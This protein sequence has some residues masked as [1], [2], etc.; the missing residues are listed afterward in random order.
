MGKNQKIH[1]SH[2]CST[3]NSSPIKVFFSFSSWQNHRSGGQKWSSTLNAPDVIVLLCSHNGVKPIVSMLPPSSGKKNTF[4]GRLK[5]ITSLGRVSKGH[6]QQS[7]KPSCNSY[8]MEPQGSAGGPPM[9]SFVYCFLIH[10]L[11]VPLKGVE[12]VQAGFL[13]LPAPH[14]SKREGLLPGPLIPLH[15]YDK[16]Q[17]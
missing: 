16:S 8:T 5:R 6:Y 9:L 10:S 15:R 3:L 14:Q 2:W 11:P 12:R 4:C 7:I 17:A 13:L 1:G